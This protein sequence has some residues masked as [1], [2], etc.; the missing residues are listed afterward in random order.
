MWSTSS[1]FA[2]AN[3]SGDG[4]I[5]KAAVQLAGEPVFAF[6]VGN[7]VTGMFSRAAWS[8]AVGLCGL[9]SHARVRLGGCVAQSVRS[10]EL[11]WPPLGPAK[12]ALLSEGA[13]S[14]TILGFAERC[15]VRANTRNVLP[16]GKLREGLSDDHGSL[17]GTPF[18][19]PQLVP[20]SPT[21]NN[22]NRGQRGEGDRFHAAD[23]ENV[24][25]KAMSG[26]GLHFFDRR[27]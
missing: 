4:G 10:A 20:R 7:R 17:L 15:R 24:V 21:H 23:A 6:Y 19:R 22:P 9:S 12:S 18:P 5:G 14:G 8:S 27:A 11:V 16:R 2:V 3:V 13:S 26:C 25:F 1:T